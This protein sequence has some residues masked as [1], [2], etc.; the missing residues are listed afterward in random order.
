[1]G[2]HSRTLRQFFNGSNII[3]DYEIAGSRRKQLIGSAADAGNTNKFD[4]GGV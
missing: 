3:L 2:R 1:M 4:T